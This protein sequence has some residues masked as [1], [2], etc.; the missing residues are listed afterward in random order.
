[1]VLIRYVF[2]AFSDSVALR[3]ARRFNM[4]KVVIKYL[5]YGGINE[6]MNNKDFYYRSSVGA[7]YS[8]WTDKGTLVMIDFLKSAK[9]MF[10]GIDRID[11]KDCNYF[12][13]LQPYQHHKSNPKDGIYVYSFS[14]SP[15]DNS[16][17]SGSCNMSRINKIQLMLNL[18]KPLS[19]TYGY[20][21][22]LYI[23]NYNFLKIT[24]G[25]AGI[26]FST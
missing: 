16:Q 5:M 25:L 15:D 4:E 17:P 10:N 13:Y 6:L 18:I 26:V 20:D 21:L 7:D 24:S 14:L 1:M 12:N 22:S 23:I 9:I 3:L 2:R 19:S 11:E 8:H